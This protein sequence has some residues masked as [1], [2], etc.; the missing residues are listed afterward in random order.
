MKTD[1]SVRETFLG[2]RIFDVCAAPHL[3]F[4][5]E[6]QQTKNTSKKRTRLLEGGAAKIRKAT[7]HLVVQK[8][9]VRGSGEQKR[10]VR[11]RISVGRFVG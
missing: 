2:R 11:E 6:Y 4:N 7:P 1:F 10:G 9:G 3:K 8:I 5:Q